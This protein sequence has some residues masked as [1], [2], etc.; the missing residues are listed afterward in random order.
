MTIH[1]LIKQ[2]HIEYAYQ[3]DDNSEDIDHH[4]EESVTLYMYPN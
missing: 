1:Q 2:H 4:D 3:N